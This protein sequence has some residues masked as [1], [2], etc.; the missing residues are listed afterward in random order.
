MLRDMDRVLWLEDGR[1]LEDG[2][3]EALLA[4]PGSRLAR[5]A[6]DH[7]PDSD[8]KDGTGGSA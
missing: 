3:P 4:D 5:W 7:D 2:R 8:P 1:I 6:A